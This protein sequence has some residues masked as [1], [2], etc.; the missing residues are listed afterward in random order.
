M[1]QIMKRGFAVIMVLVMIVGFL[2]SITIPAEA[3][4]Y[5][6]N[7]GSRGT[8]AT[9]LSSYAENWYKK[10]NVTY[11]ELSALNGSSSV[12]SVPSSQLYQKL[13]TLM[14]N[15]HSHTTSYA[16]TKELY[17][18]TDC[19]NGG[20]KISSFYSGASIGPGWGEGG[21]WNRE[22]TWPNSKGLGGQDENDIMMLRPTA[23]SENSSRGNTAYG[24][25]GSYYDPNDESKGKYNL[26]GDVAR[27]CLYVY[28]RWGN[29]SRMWGSSGVMESK[30]VL[31]KWMEEDPVDTWELGRNDAV[32]SIT[33]TRNVFVDYPELAFDLFNAEVPQNYDT[34]SGSTPSYTITA[35]PNNP[36]YGTV[37]M[38][39]KT[40]TATPKTGYQVTGYKIL[41]GTATVTRS[42]NTFTVSASADCSIQ[43][44]FDARQKITL[45]FIDH[46]KTASSLTAYT[47][48]SVTLP[49]YTGTAPSG[50]I[51][52]GWVDQQILQ[53]ESK[54]TIYSENSSYLVSHAKTFYALYAKV[55]NGSTGEMAYRLVTDASQLSQGA[56]IVITAAGSHNLALKQTGNT[57]SRYAGTI[58]KN[59]DDTITFTDSALIDILTLGAG[60]KS[61]TFSIYSEANGQ[62]LAAGTTTGSNILKLQSSVD[63]AAS[64]KISI[65]ADGTAVITSQTAS[66]RKNL[67]YDSGSNVFSCYASGQNTVN[68][69]VES[70]SGVAYYTTSPITCKHSFGAW[71]QTIAPT[72]S[73]PGEER[74]NCIHCDYF[75]TRTT[76]TTIP[77]VTEPTEPDVSTPD[78]T[79]PNDTEQ[80]TTGPVTDNK[81]QETKPGS[82]PETPQE[83]VT[84]NKNQNNS[85]PDYIV[86]IIAAILIVVVGLAA[87]LVFFL[88]KK[89]IS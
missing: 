48:D 70:G 7:W 53:S 66:D 34:P 82:T 84:N 40:I 18:Y 36:N 75:E 15:A 14:S 69:Y 38:S 49:K 35:T 80:E 29:T 41:S 44:I 6:Y 12:G 9:D 62:Y 72:D 23:T 20:G 71:K 27:I 51:F 2:P 26:H 57:S 22:H 1:N 10:Y 55:D 39:G 46:G 17:R 21:S 59:A 16:E 56:S 78:P 61:G 33:G 52:R 63:A 60:S 50:F 58:V 45:T 65:S 19:Q 88:R 85:E 13:K 64:F 25:S 37:S 83:S 81:P 47:G 32:Q 76:D 77:P 42:G 24:E 89:K 4:S 3:A 5:V 67:Q 87:V 30:D 74:R 86:M 73:T 54:P 68:I 31:L 79:E 28:V 43:I 11:A 8:V